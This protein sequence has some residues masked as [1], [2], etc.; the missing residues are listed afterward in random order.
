MSASP[1]SQLPLLLGVWQD[2]DSI[3]GWVNHRGTQD[4]NVW[5][6][7]STPII[8]AHIHRLKCIVSVTP[9]TIAISVQHWREGSA[10]M[11]LAMN[12]GLEA[13]QSQ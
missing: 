10:Y 9:H 7:N 5:L 1:V 8:M 3:C 4:T 13:V 6:Q 12:M 11:L 2:V